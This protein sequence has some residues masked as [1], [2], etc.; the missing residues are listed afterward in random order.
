MW[1]RQGH[2]QFPWR[3]TTDPYEILVSEV[4][5][6]QTQA[7]RVVR[8]Y[9]DFLA[10]FPTVADLAS[11]SLADVL[12]VWSGLGY[13]RRAQHLREA[14]T[15]V[16]TN[17]WP[18]SVE[19]LQRLPGVGPYTAA[20]VGA[21]AF[22]W[23]IAAVDTNAR[24]VLSRWH[25]EPIEEAALGRAAA[26]AMAEADAAEWNQAVMELG[27]TVCSP[28]APQCQRC[29]VAQWCAGPEVYTQPRSQRRFEGSGRQ[30]RGSIIR[31]LVEGP[32]SF[33]Q[34]IA[35]SGFDAGSVD[36]ALFSLST[37]GLVLETDLG[38]RLPD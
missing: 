12:T 15:D 19:G 20:A 9:L 38:F 34:L 27:A 17:G 7:D 18:G 11:A 35:A 37:D 16:T 6:Q 1:Y 10:A 24:R 30:L 25:G 2:R 8:Y 4:M 26:A 33:E 5:L 36:E 31:R 21:F 3:R 13:N 29:P 23:Q 32:A 28:R 22:G 14:A